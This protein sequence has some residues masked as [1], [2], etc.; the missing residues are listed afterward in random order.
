MQVAR[1][2]KSEEEVEPFAGRALRNHVAEE[3]RKRSGKATAK[4]AKQPKNSAT[5]SLNDPAAAIDPQ[6]LSLVGS[7]ERATDE[8]GVAAGN[9]MKTSAEHSPAKEPPK[10]RSKEPVAD[11]L[12]ALVKKLQDVVQAQHS[13]NLREA[14]RLRQLI[15]AMKDLLPDL[16]T[17][18]DKCCRPAGAVTTPHA[19]AEQAA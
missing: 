13:L 10:A 5:E 6:D 15:G 1:L 14:T 11:A 7:E 16:E 9:P 4:S 8:A 19:A 12:D 2:Y 18:A 3:L 17:L